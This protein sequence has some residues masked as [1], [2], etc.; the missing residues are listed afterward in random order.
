MPI[1]LCRKSLIRSSAKF[2]PC[3]K[4]A[5]GMIGF[6]RDVFS[7]V[8]AAKASQ[9]GDDAPSVDAWSQSLAASVQ[10]LV[11]YYVVLERYSILNNAKKMAKIAE[12]EPV[13]G[14][15]CV[16]SAVEDCFFICST[17]L[18]RALLTL[19]LQAVGPV[20]NVTVEVLSDHFMELLRLICAG[21]FNE[22]VGEVYKAL[23]FSGESAAATASAIK[24]QHG[25]G[26]AAATLEDQFSATLDQLWTNH[27]RARPPAILPPRGE[28]AW[29]VQDRV[30]KALATA[31]AEVKLASSGN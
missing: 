21:G 14:K 6:L 27:P 13:D 29:V 7:G 28:L 26:K 16:L 5:Q 20:I 4:L 12:I 10:E 22:E 17:A 3:A 19:N 11:G 2:A 31:E 25:I 9:Q 8:C 15:V 18:N 1:P 24:E 30:F 23:E